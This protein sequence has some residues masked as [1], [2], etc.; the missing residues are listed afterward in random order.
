MYD[1]CGGFGAA[2]T[3]F[4]CLLHIMALVSEATTTTDDRAKRQLLRRTNDVYRHLAGPGAVERIDETDSPLAAVGAVRRLLTSIFNDAD[5]PVLVAAAEKTIA[6]EQLRPSQS[7]SRTDSETSTVDEVQRTTALPNREHTLNLRLSL[8]TADSDTAS[9][10]LTLPT[11]AS[12]PK[13]PSTRDVRLST[14]TNGHDETTPSKTIDSN[15][16]TSTRS[17]PDLRAPAKRR[18]LSRLGL[19]LVRQHVAG[20]EMREEP[21]EDEDVESHP[22]I[23]RVRTMWTTEEELNL[24]RGVEKLGV[25]VWARIRDRY[26]SAT[27]RTNTDLKDKWRLLMKP[28]NA[29]HF[30]KLQSALAKQ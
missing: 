1:S 8:S 22:K 5:V 23:R 25:G 20:I 30:Q 11:D 12:T 2:Q 18:I 28:S 6:D 19:A 26:F 7:A 3:H 14:P 9:N 10:D 29:E 24:L 17:S 27:S 15:E 16:S 13:R 4:G 21:K